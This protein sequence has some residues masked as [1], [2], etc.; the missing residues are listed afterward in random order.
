M[1]M[2]KM[3]P[4]GRRSYMRIQR[5]LFARLPPEEQ[6]KWMDAATEKLAEVGAGVPT[7]TAAEHAL[8]LY[9]A[10]LPESESCHHYTLRSECPHCSPG[11][12]ESAP[13]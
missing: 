11:E 12:T 10:S 6:K 3:H 8:H 1:D 5:D 13:K 4:S 2:S 9:I 7:G